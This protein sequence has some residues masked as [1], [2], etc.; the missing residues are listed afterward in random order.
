MTDLQHALSLF[1]NSLGLMLFCSAQMAA[2]VMIPLGWP[3]LWFQVLAAFVLTSST[4]HLGWWW[5]LGIVLIAGAGELLD[6]LLN[7]LG[8]SS[9]GASR[10]AA[11]GALLFGFVFAFFGF[12]IPLPI[13]GAGAMAMSF[14]GTF[15]GAVLGEMAY[16]RKLHPKL[17]VA[18]GAVIGRACGIAAKLSL[19]F[20]AAGVVFMALMIELFAA[21]TASK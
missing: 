16:E 19:G 13:P 18:L 17:H 1:G 5:T 11:W 6:M 15:V 21:V 2:L 14:V 7:N 3:G 12:L 9:V 10:H 8:F 20:I 4:G